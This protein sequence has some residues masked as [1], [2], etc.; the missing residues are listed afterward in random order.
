[1]KPEFFTSQESFRKW[2][3]KNYSSIEI[4]VGFYKT[5][6]AKKGITYKEALDVALC[7]G[8]IDGIRKGIDAE[9]WMIRFTPR[10]EKSIWSNVNIN[11][12]NELLKLGLMKEPGIAAFK[13]R[14]EHKSGIYSYEQTK[15]NG[16]DKTFENKFK[17]NKKAWDWFQLQAPS[18]K[19][20]VSFWVMSAKKEETRLK[21]LETLIS[22]CK[23]GRKLDSHKWG[24]KK[25]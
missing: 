13:K 1:M 22:D 2:M 14:L 4:V 17:A 6:S 11:R 9:T 25:K 15:I 3:Q 23:N 16:L 10:K 18:Y 21:R 5:T 24:E 20:V 12:V 8:W 19:K 7:Y